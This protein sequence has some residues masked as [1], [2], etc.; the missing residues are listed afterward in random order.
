MTLCFPRKDGQVLLGLKKVRLGE[1][2]WNGFGG[3]VQAGES[4]EAAARRETKEECGIDVDALEKV[5]VLTFTHPERAPIEVHIFTTEDFTGEPAES[6]EM[7]P[8]WFHKDEVP[9]R[10]MWSSDLYWWPW[11]WKR[12]KFIGEFEFDASDR[13]LGHEMR[14]ATTLP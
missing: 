14:A 13:V 2:R 7:S 6:D 3:K 4:V 1:G 8:R 10:E 9:F 11:F 12:R 5:G